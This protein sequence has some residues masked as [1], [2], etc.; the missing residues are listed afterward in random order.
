VLW[1]GRC[2]FSAILIAI[3]LRKP[4]FRLPADSKRASSTL[5]VLVY[6]CVLERISI[7]FV[8]HD[9]CCPSCP[10]LIKVCLSYEN[11]LIPGNLHYKEPNPNNESL[12]TGI[13]KVST[14]ASL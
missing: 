3:T 14:C 11:G 5:F 1:T 10:G 9:M 4:V 12:K 13:L 2:V 7:L 6:I 8:V